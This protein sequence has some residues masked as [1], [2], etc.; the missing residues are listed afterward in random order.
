MPMCNSRQSTV[1]K[2]DG[3]LHGKTS[4]ATSVDNGFQYQFLSTMLTNCSSP[5]I[6]VHCMKFLFFINFNDDNSNPILHSGPLSEQ[7]T[8]CQQQVRVKKANNVKP[9]N[10]V[11]NEGENDTMCLFP[12]PLYVLWVLLPWPVC[13]WIYILACVLHTYEHVCARVH[14]GMFSWHSQSLSRRIR[15]FPAA[16]AL[17]AQNTVVCVCLIETARDIYGTGSAVTCHAP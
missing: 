3:L 12:A 11:W 4:L 5:N 6:Y 7:Y 8:F 1:L 14:S 17:P 16:D 2:W 15:A 13:Q 9:N 10:H